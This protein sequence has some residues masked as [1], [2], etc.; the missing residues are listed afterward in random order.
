MKAKLTLS[1]KDER[2][3]EAVVK[4]VSPDNRE[5]SSGLSIET[6]RRGREVLTLVKCEMRLET[7]LATIDDLLRCI[8]VAEKAFS[9]TKNA[10][11]N[12]HENDP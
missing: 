8:S 7:F 3:A 9:A 5:V 6:F 10:L 11:P 1:Y 2:E 12:L 4:A